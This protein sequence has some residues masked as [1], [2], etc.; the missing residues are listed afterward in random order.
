MG[1]D[2][3]AE[4][5]HRV[6]SYQFQ[7]LAGR[8][9]WLISGPKKANR[10]GETASVGSRQPSKQTPPALLASDTICL[11]SY[12]VSEAAV[13]PQPPPCADG[14]HTATLHAKR[15]RRKVEGCGEGG[16]ALIVYDNI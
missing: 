8:N 2:T 11:R 14:E 7:G 6:T 16:F 13:P 5:R 1:Q 10:A 9:I 12:S 4:K 3:A 15:K